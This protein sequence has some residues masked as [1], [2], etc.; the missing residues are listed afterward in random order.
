MMN[1]AALEKGAM[2]EEI[3]LWHH[4]RARGWDE[5]GEEGGLGLPPNVFLLCQL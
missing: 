3:E 1:L 5:I 2:L 4:E